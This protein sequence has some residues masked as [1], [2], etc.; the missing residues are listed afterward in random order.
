MPNVLDHIRLTKAAYGILEKSGS[1]KGHFF[2]EYRSIRKHELI[3]GPDVLGMIY[4]A[5][6][7]GAWNHR[8]CIYTGKVGA[9]RQ[10]ARFYR[11]LVA[12]LKAHDAANAS[13][14]AAW[15]SHFVCDSLSPLH[16]CIDAKKVS[17]YKALRKVKE[18]IYHVYIES[19]LVRSKLSPDIPGTAGEGFSGF[20]KKVDELR[21]I[22]IMGI[23]RRDGYR[24]V[25]D[26]Y[27]NRIYPEAIASVAMLWAVAV[28]EAS[29]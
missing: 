7:Y 14:D 27:K 22:D 6:D 1:L 2:P 26:V 10:S 25:F 4:K 9:F 29:K 20:K 17:R 19:R 8:N 24:G 11:K 16:M 13:K 3:M 18:S 21:G 23:L 5:R 12:D 28:D 15:L